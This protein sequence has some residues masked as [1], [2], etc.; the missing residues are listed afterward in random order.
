[1]S[2]EWTDYT[3]YS[4]EPT[5]TEEIVE[6]TEV[7]ETAELP[8]EVLMGSIYNCDKVYVR[9]EPSKESTDVTILAKDAEVLISGTVDDDEVGGWYKICTETGIEGYIVSKFVKINS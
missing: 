3:A 8:E 4:E 6:E 7:E 5:E 2:L 1:M 9:E